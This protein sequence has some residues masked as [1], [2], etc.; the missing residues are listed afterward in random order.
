MLILNHVPVTFKACFLFLKYR[1]S[2]LYVYVYKS[3]LISLIY[4]FHKAIF[5]NNK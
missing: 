1:E 5:Q 4:E 3:N 2:N